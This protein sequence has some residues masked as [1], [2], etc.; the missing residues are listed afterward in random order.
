VNTESYLLALVSFE[1]TPNTLSVRYHYIFAQ[2]LSC[3]FELT[4]KAGI[5]WNYLN[6][7]ITSK[8][9]S[10]DDVTAPST[11]NQRQIMDI[12]GISVNST[13]TLTTFVEK[14]I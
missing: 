6:S 7:G 9:I 14:A 13:K 8:E 10:I 3:L 2:L 5:V 11:S 12:F 4:M 1:R